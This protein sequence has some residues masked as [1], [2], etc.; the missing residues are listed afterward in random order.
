MKIV[1]GGITAAASP[2]RKV[3]V[4]PEA[5]G[6]LARPIY[7]PSAL[8]QHAG[9]AMVGVRLTLDLEGRVAS[10]AP[11]LAVL[12]SPGPFAAEFREAVETVVRQW[13]FRPAEIRHLEMVADPGGPY[14]H[15]A[16]REPIEWMLDV[17]FRFSASGQVLAGP[18]K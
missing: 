2:N 11:S 12:S 17:Q 9:A 1:K 10:V 3:V 5:I 8:A 14:L 18:S 15:L 4:P 16:S 6:E 7:P 13:C